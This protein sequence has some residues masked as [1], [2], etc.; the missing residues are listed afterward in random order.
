MKTLNEVKNQEQ[1]KALK[2]WVEASFRAS[3]IAPTGF[4]KTRLITIAAGEHIRRNPEEN[5]LVI[6]PTEN[7]RDNEIPIDFSNWGYESEYK[8]LEVECIQTVYK[9]S[10]RHFSGVIVDEVHTVLTEE[11]FKF[12]ENNT[13]DKIL[14]L[15][16][17]IP[18]E[19]SK[20]DLLAKIAP[21]S[22]T[23]TLDEARLLGLVSDY[24]VF[25]LP[26][27]FTSSEL[28]AYKKADN[29]FNYASMQF[30]YGFDSF[31]KATAA[32]N[33]TDKEAKAFA[34]MYYNSMKKRKDICYNAIN[35][36]VAVKQILD[37]F[38]DRYSLVFSETI[39]FADKVQSLL[40]T[41][42]AS[43]NSKM[44]KK[45][46]EKTLRLFNDPDSKKRVISS[47]KALDVGFNVEDISL[48]ITAAG[49]SKEL[50]S[51]QRLGRSLRVK[52]GK[53]AIMVNLYVPNT[54]EVKW[55]DKRTKNH[56]P[57]WIKKVED[58]KI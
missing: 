34:A 12:F 8:K 33:G 5:W 10:G 38:P 21:I 29:T 51:T 7:I 20:I 36:V 54:Q 52:E 50:Q 30:G 26:V 31:S 40:G 35:K 49:S 41:E 17:T 11:Y 27:E 16:A 15:T 32:L 45:E 28:A 22:Y 39:E 43:F 1:M 14:C 4:G 3:I 47:V 2:A 55:V 42:C 9:W 58:I 37:L 19:Q 23:L 6:T 13:F 44:K 53:I 57:I 48:C 25:N 46:R 24:L 18:E 56:S